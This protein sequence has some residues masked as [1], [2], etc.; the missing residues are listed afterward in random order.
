MEPLLQDAL[1]NRPELKLLRLDQNA[2]ETFV[3]AEH[4]LRKPTVSALATFGGV[5]AG[6]AAVSRRVRGGGR[7]RLNSDFQWRAIQS[8]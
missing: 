1:N 3:H 2:A 5:P 8:A 7:Q 6:E 4:D